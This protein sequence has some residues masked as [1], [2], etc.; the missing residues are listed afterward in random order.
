MLEV[1]FNWIFILIA[2]AVIMAFFF[3]IV[4]KQRSISEQKLALTVLNEFDAITTGASVAKGTAQR[5]DIPRSGIDFACS[6]ECTCA[7]QVGPWSRDYGDKLIFAPKRIVGK[8]VV[9][10]ALDWSVPFRVTN[11]LLVTNDRIKYFF[12]YDDSTASQQLKRRLE[13]DLPDQVN[14]DF[15]TADRI[16]PEGPECVKNENYQ[17]VKFVF[18]ETV[19]N[20]VEDAFKDTDLTAVHITGTDALFF[21]C[22]RGRI[23][24]CDQEPESPTQFIGDAGLYGVIFAY[25]WNMYKCNMR[26]ATARLGYISQIF[27]GRTDTLRADPSFLDCPYS[28][29]ALTTLGSTARAQSNT[30]DNFLSITAQTKAL[31]TQNEQLLRQSCPTVY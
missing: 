3:S 26:A 20:I 4:Q 10:W 8:D 7:F 9:F 21:H 1:Q 15:I 28:T 2:G 14:A 23:G 17:Q 22:P 19:P 31:E 5:I 24:T 12:V 25:D 29:D 18:L 30:L 6:D 11:F 27:A 13:S 16:C